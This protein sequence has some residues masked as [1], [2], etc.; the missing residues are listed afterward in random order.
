VFILLTFCAYIRPLFELKVASVQMLVYIYCLAGV[1]L[2]TGSIY[3]WQA[4]VGN[5]TGS[6][7]HVSSLLYICLLQVES[8]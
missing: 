3:S 5:F 7:Y 8:H 1:R 6:C 4:S 2:S